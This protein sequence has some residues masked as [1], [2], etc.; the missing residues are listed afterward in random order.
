MT[1]GLLP[2]GP[3]WAYKWISTQTFLSPLIYV[4]KVNYGHDFAIT[5]LSETDASRLHS[6]V[7]ASL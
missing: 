2:E 6:P 7:K 3:K 4:S 5:E 1:F